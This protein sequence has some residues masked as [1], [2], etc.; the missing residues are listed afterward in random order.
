MYLLFV[1]HKDLIFVRG[2]CNRYYWDYEHRSEY[3]SSWL[4]V[5]C[6]YSFVFVFCTLWRELGEFR[7]LSFDLIWSALRKRSLPWGFRRCH[8]KTMEIVFLLQASTI[9]LHIRLWGP[10]RAALAIW[11]VR[12]RPGS[13]NAHRGHGGGT[14]FSPGQPFKPPKSLRQI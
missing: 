6:E 7:R 4:L 5:C 10:L 12:H 2:E 8:R 9:V 13:R 14:P 11:R 3:C 1:T